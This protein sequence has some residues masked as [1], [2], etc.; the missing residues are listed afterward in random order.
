MYHSD[1]NLMGRLQF[2]MRDN[3]HTLFI[4]AKWMR[5]DP[6]LRVSVGL[7]KSFADTN[8]GTSSVFNPD[9]YYYDH[10]KDWNFALIEQVV[11]E[12]PNIIFYEWINTQYNPAVEVFSIFH[13]MNIPVICFWWDFLYEGSREVAKLLTPFIHSHVIVDTPVAFTNDSRKE[14]YK[15]MWPVPMNNFFFRN[16]EEKTIPVSFPGGTIKG[17]AGGP[18][19]EYITFLKEN[20]IDIFVGGTKKEESTMEYADNL[21]RTKLALNVSQT[22]LMT[23]NGKEQKAASIKGRSFEAINCGAVLL[24]P[25][26]SFLCFYLTPDVDYITYTD[27]Q[28]LLNKIRYY[29]DNEKE[30]LEIA[31]HG[32]QTMQQNYNQLKYW[33]TILGWAE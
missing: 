7:E 31:E 14:V 11:I 33:N 15:P 8:L 10:K 19:E 12:K 28:D 25:A 16:E 26:G 17:G 23:S 9:G 3:M 13:K 5:N 27:E 22:F 1:L 29:L 2:F 24:E 32:Y 4:R 21:R 20:G 30:R 18:R 6:T